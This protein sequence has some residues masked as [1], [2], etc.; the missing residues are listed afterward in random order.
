MLLLNRVD[1]Y[2]GLRLINNVFGTK[3]RIAFS[4]GYTEKYLYSRWNDIIS[5]KNGNPSIVSDAQVKE[6]IYGK[7]SLNLFR[8]PAPR[9]YKE[10]G[11]R[12]ISGGLM[13]S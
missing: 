4:L 7:D 9:H 2:D 8:L 13:P 12:H 3:E 1:G 11:G 10:D 6:V 5:R